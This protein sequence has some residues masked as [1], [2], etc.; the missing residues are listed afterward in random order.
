MG[1]LQVSMDLTDLKGLTMLSK[2]AGQRLSF[3][4]DKLDPTTMLPAPYKHFPVYYIDENSFISDKDADDYH[5]KVIKL[6][7]SVAP[8]T[9][10]GA[11]LLVLGMVGVAGAFLHSRRAAHRAGRL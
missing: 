8:L 7:K 9:A 6:L 2:A 3:Y 10:C 5:K 4:N 1:R 11:V